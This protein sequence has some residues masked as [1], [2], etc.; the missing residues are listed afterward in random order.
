[1]AN[2]FKKGDKVI[3]ITGSSKGK[4]GNILSIEND[5]VI[6]DGVNLA[7]FHKKP[8]SS[9][10]GEIIKKESSIHVSNISHNEDGKIVKVE[11]ELGQGD[12]KAFTRKKRI[13]RKTKKRI[14]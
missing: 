5:R 8:T 12:G 1:M 7:T 11:F 6:V 9:Q 14:D 10:A 4:I 13:S 2:K 3:I